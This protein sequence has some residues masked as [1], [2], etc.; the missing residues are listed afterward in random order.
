MIE[1]AKTSKYV[2]VSWNSRDKKWVASIY[3][4]RKKQYGGCYIDERDAAHAV[5]KLC[6]EYGVPRKNP[7]LGDPPG[8]LKVHS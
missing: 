1:A 4:N 3:A 6:D 7:E 8:D 2:G 5:N